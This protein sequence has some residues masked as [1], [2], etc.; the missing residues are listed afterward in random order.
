MSGGVA[1]V[2]T[3]PPYNLLRDRKELQEAK[4]LV[5]SLQDSEDILQQLESRFKKDFSARVNCEQ[6]DLYSMDGDL[7][8]G[9]DLSP[10]KG[11]VFPGEEDHLKDLL[12][13]FVDETSSIVAST[14]LQD[15]TRSRR[16]FLKVFPRD[17][18]RVMAEKVAAKEVAA[19][20]VMEVNDN[21]IDNNKIDD[22]NNDK[23]KDIEDLVVDKVRGFLKYPRIKGY[24]RPVGQRLDDYKEVYDT[25]KMR[26]ESRI[27]ASRC[28]DCG[29]PFCQSSTTGCPLNNQI[30]AFNDSVSKGDLPSALHT[31]L[32]TNNFPEFTGRVCPA[33]CEGSCVLGINSDPVAIK[34][35]ELSISEFGF[36][37]GMIAH[38]L[39][40][41][42]ASGNR[43]SGFSVAIVGSGPAGLAAAAQLALAG[44]GVTVF[45]R[46]ER[47]GGLLRYGI[48]NMK[49]DK[50]GVLDRRI[51]L[52]TSVQGVVF[53]TG[54]DVGSPS[55]PVSRLDAFD[56]VGVCVG[57]TWPRDLPIPGR[58]TLKGIYFAMEYLSRGGESS[59]YVGSFSASGKKVLVIGGGDT[60]CDCIATALREGALDVTALEILP[61]PPPSRADDNPWPQWPKVFRLDYGHEEVKARFNK[62]PRLFCMSA[63]EF[64]GDSEGNVVGVK[65]VRVEWTRNGQ[66]GWKMTEVED[67]TLVIPCDLVLLA[68]GFLG[69]QKYLPSALGLEV[70][71][72]SN[73]ILVSGGDKRPHF[74]DDSSRPFHAK[75]NIFL[76]GDCRRG[77][78]LV[79]HAINEGRQ[80][81]RAIDLYFKRKGTRIESSLSCVGGIVLPESKK[82][83]SPL[84]A[85]A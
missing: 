70:D 43:R 41:K 78:S 18:H 38:L 44:H 58:A 47:E 84:K 48:P 36:Q 32:Q 63:R 61:Q 5:D 17:F 42:H 65:A 59:S 75:D 1:W 4:E 31:L 23:T 69:P 13:E 56:A 16:F 62:D 20:E 35:V 51:N 71:A 37:S 15:W 24:L 26:R 2:Y 57:A 33:P 83:A 73:N 21:K 68:M 66:G 8:C 54:V 9:D 80:M 52:M 10:K 46:E 40:Q 39:A 49:L 27:Q 81:A 29:I 72:R 74:L 76:S 12:Q 60:G 3:F 64:V 22:D 11:G 19:Q 50:E 67:S 77:Q 14:L 28:M 53:E 85:A 25:E 79:V 55:F 6:V 7:F 34:S 82:E 45:E 30:P